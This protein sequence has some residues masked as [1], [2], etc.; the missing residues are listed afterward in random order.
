M[1]TIELWRV[2]SVCGY[3]NSVTSLTARLMP[4]P[5]IF[6]TPIYEERFVVQYTVMQ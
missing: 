2:T 6:A 3:P 5:D 4:S 1:V